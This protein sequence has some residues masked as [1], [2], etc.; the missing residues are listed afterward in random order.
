MIRTSR[1][2][3]NPLVRTNCALTDLRDDLEAWCQ[4]YVTAFSRYDAEA[5][6]AHWSFPALTTQAGK[7]YAFKSADHFA[8][9][10]GLLLGFYRAQDV[11]KVERSV[12]DC[13]L[14]HRDAVS[15]T[16]AD[17]MF[18]SDGVAIVSW[19]AAYVLQRVGGQWK[20]VMAIADGET[21][22]WAARGTPL[23]G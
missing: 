21:E 1:N 11:A 15:M 3:S 16:V 13:Q 19:H 23:G 7:S 10:T 8:K 12:I 6:A 20:A 14:L 9:N 17:T 18:A 4:S 2:I 5:I 22:A